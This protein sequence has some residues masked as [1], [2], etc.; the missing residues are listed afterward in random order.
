MK[1]LEE[2]EHEIRKI[3]LVISK[4]KQKK[5]FKKVVFVLEKLGGCVCGK[6]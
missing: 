5:G 3:T 1:I 2:T 4:T 6:T